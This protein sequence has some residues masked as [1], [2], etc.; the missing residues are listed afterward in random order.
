MLNLLLVW[1]HLQQ[2]ELR[3]LHLVQNVSYDAVTYPTDGL[4]G[5][6]SISTVEKTTAHYLI[7]SCYAGVNRLI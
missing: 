3:D 2:L 7:V 6:R 5:S 4:S 1:Q